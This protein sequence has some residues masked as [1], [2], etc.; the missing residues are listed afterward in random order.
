[1]IYF[2]K[3]NKT[4]IKVVIRWLIEKVSKGVIIRVKSVGADE[5]LSVGVNIGLKV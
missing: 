5:G 2:I 1:M 3:L 4:Y